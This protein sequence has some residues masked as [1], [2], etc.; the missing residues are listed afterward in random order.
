MMTRAFHETMAIDALQRARYA[1]NVKRNLVEA[2]RVIVSA[3]VHLS[4]ITTSDRLSR[5]M[6]RL[7]SAVCKLDRAIANQTSFA[8]NH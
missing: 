5:R 6:A 3:R 1:L 4:S 7:W 2:N 8:F